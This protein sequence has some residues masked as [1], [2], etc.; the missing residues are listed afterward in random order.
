[1]TSADGLSITNSV[2]ET[3]RAKDPVQLSTTLQPAVVKNRN[4]VAKRLRIR[5]NMGGEEYCLL[6]LLQPQ[7]DITDL[8]SAERIQ[9]GHGLVQKDEIRVIDQGLRNSHALNHA[10]GE[11]AQRNIAGC[12]ET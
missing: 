10:L 1:M 2:A 6:P 11:S 5:E 12:G 9:T 8:P 4:P 3:P 7:D